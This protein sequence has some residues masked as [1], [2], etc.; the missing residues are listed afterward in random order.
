MGAPSEAHQPLS[1]G[2]GSL[3][4]RALGAGQGSGC[5]HLSLSFFQT[6]R[7]K[8]KLQLAIIAGRLGPVEGAGAMRGLPG[9]TGGIQPAAVTPPGPASPLQGGPGL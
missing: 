9:S 8:R 5:V 7:W 2:C 1:R 4:G 3:G 6:K